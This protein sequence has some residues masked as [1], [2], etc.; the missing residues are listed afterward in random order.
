MKYAEEDQVANQC[1]G[2][3]LKECLE[4]TNKAVDTMKETKKKAT[5]NT[6][7]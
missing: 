2:N 5:V 3:E 7:K 1:L 4:E 6:Q